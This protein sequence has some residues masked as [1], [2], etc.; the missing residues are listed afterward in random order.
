MDKNPNMNTMNEYQDW[1]S[2]DMFKADYPKITKA[3]ARPFHLNNAALAA[4]YL[5]KLKAAHPEA[6][7]IEYC[8]QWLCLTEKH[9]SYVKNLI[10]KSIMQ[11]RD[12][13]AALESLLESL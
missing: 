6:Q 2:L 3:K 5:S 13:V 8:G 11:K 1:N 7:C 12:E 4:Y 10:R 9:V